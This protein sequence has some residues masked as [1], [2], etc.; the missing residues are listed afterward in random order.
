MQLLHIQKKKK[1]L[2]Q[3]LIYIL[4]VAVGVAES[5]QL[6]IYILYITIE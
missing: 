2:M 1:V 3:L 5:V 6:L 4:Y